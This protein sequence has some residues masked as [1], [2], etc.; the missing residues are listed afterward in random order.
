ME[1]DANF[2]VDLF[3]HHAVY[4]PIEGRIEMYLVSQREQHV[5][6]ALREFSFAEGEPIRTELSYK[7]TL[8]D[9][10]DLATASSFVVQQ[11]W[12][13]ENRHFSVLYLA[14]STAAQ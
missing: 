7:Y 11:T 8:R 4:N 5:R 3:W 14:C 13:D 9:L 1:L 6:V 12:T 2:Q 10:Q